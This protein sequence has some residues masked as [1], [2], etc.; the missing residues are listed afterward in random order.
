MCGW[1]RWHHAVVEHPPERQTITRAEGEY[2]VI[3]DVAK[4]Q[5]LG[6]FHRWQ[7]GGQG[8]DEAWRVE[9]SA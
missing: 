8:F 1:P 9:N 5:A 4:G 7:R 6:G 3:L 2:V